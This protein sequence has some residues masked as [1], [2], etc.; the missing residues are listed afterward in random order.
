M[1]GFA[2][3]CGHLLGDYILQSDWMAKNKSN[4]RPGREPRIP[5]ETDLPSEADELIRARWHWHDEQE[6][7]WVG[8]LACTVHCFYYTLCVWLC[9]CW[10][11]PWWG[12]VV[13]FLAHWPLDRF[14][15]AA[16]WMRHISSQAEFASPGH[17]MHPWSVVAVDNTFHLLTLLGVGLLAL[18]V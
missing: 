2:L 4:P 11:L 18:G 1:I 8:H 13:C 9:A 14:R 16:W 15:L 17:P 10:W 3:L 7:W 5:N 12:V 6:D